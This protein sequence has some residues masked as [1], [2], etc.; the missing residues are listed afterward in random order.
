[1]KI[2]PVSQPYTLRAVAEA[3]ESSPCMDPADSPSASTPLPSKS[4][5]G[6]GMRDVPSC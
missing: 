3:D 5:G 6:Q 1:M 4:A 2:V